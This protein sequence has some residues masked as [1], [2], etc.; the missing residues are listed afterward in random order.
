MIWVCY[1]WGRRG[2]ARSGC[3][4]ASTLKALFSPFSGSGLAI[5]LCV[6][7]LQPQVY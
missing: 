2:I 5:L 7:D 6:A 4:V 3:K 1:S